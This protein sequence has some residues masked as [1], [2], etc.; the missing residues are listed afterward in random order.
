MALLGKNLFSNRFT[1]SRSSLTCT[2]KCGNACFGECENPSSNAYFGDQFTTPFSRRSALRAG[3]L[4]VVTVGG[5]A[6][7]AACSPAE[8]GASAGSG[9]TTTA[10]VE[11]TSAEGMRFEAVQPNTKD[12]V[13]IPAGYAQSILIAWGDPVIEGAPEFD[14]NNQ[15]AEAAEK[16]FGFNNDFAGLIEH[17]DDPN[18]MIYMCSHEYTTE[19]MMFPNYDADNPTEEQAKIGWAG[20]G[21]TILEVSKVEGTGEL[22]REFG[23]LNRRI[24]GTT[25]FKLVGPAKGTDLV[26]TTADPAGETVKG[27]FNN[28]SGGVTPWNT[29]LSGEENFDQYFAADENMKDEKAKKSLER[30]GIKDPETDRKWERFD[31]RF[32]VA[33]EP[34]EPNRFGWVV[35]INPLDPQSTPIKHTALGRFKHEAGNIHITKDGTVVCY[36]G[37]DSRFEYIYKFVSTK[38]FEEGNIEHNLS[39]LDHGT[40][41]V[42]KLEGN[43]PA[44]EIDGSGVLPEDGAFDGEGTWVKLLT[45]DTENNTF[46]SHVDGFTAEEVA[47]FTREAADAVGATKMD[48]PEDMEVHPDT[49]KV[50]V[51]LT[52]NSY[53]GATGEN[54][55]KNKEEPMEWAPVKENKNGLVMELTD[56]HAGES[57]K[58]NLFLVCGDPK[59][60]NTY[61][62]GFDKEKVSPISCPDNLAFDNH[63]NLWISTDGNALDTNDGL[64][65]VTTEGDTRGEL[66]CFLTVPAGAETCGPIVDDDRVMV[67]VQHPGEA[68][69]ATFESPTSHW[70]DGGNSTPRPAV[71]VVWKEDGKIGTDA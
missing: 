35:E 39:I 44:D 56:D 41:Y 65:A 67:N 47:V 19:P 50:Y 55:K 34:N 2:Y 58:W 37:D 38:K 57:L 3:G 45:S 8:E 49:E 28:C 43:S 64:Y 52:N 4:T 15:T 16:Q 24:T 14:V 42:A 54:A 9:S 22:K 12:E 68:D 21:H 1:S 71:V 26:K 63:G 27:T 36:S 70:P 7:L 10:K 60:A 18:R 53:R 23:P 69:D 25:E 17:P 6:A 51:A 33:K 30:F 46:V 40:L 62:G 59:E 29:M 31:D 11:L 13:V 48:R 32:D 20:H 5:G 61:F 66:K